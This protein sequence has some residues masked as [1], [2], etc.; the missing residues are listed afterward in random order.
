MN[1]HSLSLT[2]SLSLSLSLTHTHTH[3]HSILWQSKVGRRIAKQK[4][5]DG[6]GDIE[7]GVRR[8]APPWVRTVE[9]TMTLF[10]MIR[11]KKD[12]M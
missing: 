10:E 11:T 6:N 9:S 12:D 4:L 1:K 2:L 3:T 7:M 5:L 8:E